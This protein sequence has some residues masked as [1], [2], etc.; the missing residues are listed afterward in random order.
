MNIGIDVDGVL[1]D[2][3]SYQKKYAKKYFKD[4]YEYNPEYYDIRDAVCC[5]EKERKSFWWRHI[6]RYCVLE[7]PRTNASEIIKKL[8]DDGHKIYIITGRVFVTQNSFK[9]ALFRF[10]LTNWLKRNKIVYDDIA[11]CS[12]TNSPKDKAAS[13]L[14]YKIDVML[15]DRADNTMELSK[16]TKVLCFSAGYNKECA[17]ENIV[18]VTSFDEAYKFIAKIT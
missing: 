12:D 11:L 18:R 16:I 14:K 4:K 8:R 6:W 3:E 10:M 5:G 15:E 2:F 9:G 1:N 7:P 17:G 13:C